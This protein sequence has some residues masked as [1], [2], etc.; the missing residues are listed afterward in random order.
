MVVICRSLQGAFN[1]NIG[2]NRAM[3]AEITDATNI[4]QAFSL[5][6]LVWG[7]GVCIGYVHYI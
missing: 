3:I 4:A 5:V 7:V 2:I 6:P 1:G